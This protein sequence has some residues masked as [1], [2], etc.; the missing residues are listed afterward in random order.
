MAS[1]R[2]KETGILQFFSS[3][4]PRT[5]EAVVIEEVCRDDETTPVVDLDQTAKPKKTSSTPV[6]DRVQTATPKK[7]SSQSVTAT[8]P[9]GGSLV[10][11][12]SGNHHFLGFQ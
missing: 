2:R 6:V 4:R 8:T 1:K 10:L 12:Q 3:K 5:E 9:T 11:I 7:T